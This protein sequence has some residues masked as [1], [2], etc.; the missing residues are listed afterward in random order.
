MDWYKQL[1]CRDKK[2]ISDLVSFS[3]DR[4]NNLNLPILVLNKMT[5]RQSFVY[6]DVLEW[7]VRNLVQEKFDL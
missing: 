7:R 2:T 6:K 4:E 5:F 3:V 1:S